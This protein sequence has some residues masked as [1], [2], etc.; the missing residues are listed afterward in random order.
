MYEVVR[1]I[2]LEASCGAHTHV[3]EVDLLGQPNINL[4]V[5]FGLGLQLELED[6]IV[7]GLDLD[8]VVLDLLVAGGAVDPD[9]L[10]GAWRQVAHLVL[11]Q[12]EDLGDR[13]HHDHSCLVHADVGDLELLLDGHVWFTTDED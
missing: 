1:Q 7:L 12:S 6:V 8:L 3:S 4:E 13:F 11:L 10:A 9:A 2:H 5:L